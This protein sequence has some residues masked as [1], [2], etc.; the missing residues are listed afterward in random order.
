MP[1]KRTPR[2]RPQRLPLLTDDRRATLLAYCKLEEFEDDPEVMA[3]L[4]TFYAAAS[5]YM[6]E[7]GISLPPE[8]TLRQA[9]YDLCVNYLVLDGWDKRDVSIASAAA[10]DN[11]V[12]RRMLNQLKLTEG[13]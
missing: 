6:A 10:A 9:Q 7:A 5:G 3:L 8:G 11:P 2:S 1:V 13:V 12:F 4:E